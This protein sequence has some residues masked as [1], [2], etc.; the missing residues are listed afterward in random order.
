MSASDIFGSNSPKKKEIGFKGRSKTR[1]LSGNGSLLGT[2]MNGST[3]RIRNVPKKEG[4]FFCIICK[5]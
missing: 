2:S 4:I 5:I 1:Y 3:M